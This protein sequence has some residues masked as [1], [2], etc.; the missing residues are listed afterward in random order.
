MK[1]DSCGAKKRVFDLT[2]LLYIIIASWYVHIIHTELRAIKE[3][4]YDLKRELEIHD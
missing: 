1:C 2:P 3:A 4:T